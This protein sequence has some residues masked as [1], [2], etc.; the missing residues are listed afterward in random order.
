MPSLV[1]GRGELLGW[2]GRAERGIESAGT[3]QFRGHRPD[4]EFGMHVQS[5]ADLLL[6]CDHPSILG[7]FL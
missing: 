2:C 3:C 1:A 4:A 7:L 5:S 6:H